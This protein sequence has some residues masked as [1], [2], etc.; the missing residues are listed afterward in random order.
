MNI[1]HIKKK[2]KEK[3]EGFLVKCPEALQVLQ[4]IENYT[5]LELKHPEF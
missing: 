5:H 1:G 4:M 3:R 2:E